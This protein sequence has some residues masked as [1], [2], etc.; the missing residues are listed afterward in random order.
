[1]PMGVTI[2]FDSVATNRLHKTISCLFWNGLC[3][4]KNW[5]L[6]CLKKSILKSHPVNNH[7]QV[8]PCQQGHQLDQQ[9]LSKEDEHIPC[10]TFILL[11]GRRPFAVQY[12][13]NCA[14]SSLEA[15]SILREDTIVDILCDI[16]FFLLASL[17]I[18]RAKI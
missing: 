18:L 10:K 8:P 13:L 14:V 15:I 5:A 3:F 9:L 4:P 17:T 6:H 1:M 12:E 11:M 16:I 2:V 7:T